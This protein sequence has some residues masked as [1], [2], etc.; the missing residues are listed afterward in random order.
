[1]LSM[2]TLVTFLMF[3]EAGRAAMIACGI[4]FAMGLLLWLSG[5]GD[6]PPHW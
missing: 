2:L 1:M 4:L 6:R 5:M 3:R